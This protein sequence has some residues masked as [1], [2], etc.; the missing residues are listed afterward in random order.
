MLKPDNLRL[1]S[2]IS[3]HD[4]EMPTLTAITAS[5][6]R[7][8]VVQPRPNAADTAKAALFPWLYVLGHDV[9][10]PQ[11]L[12]QVDL[13]ELFGSTKY[14]LCRYNLQHDEQMITIDVWG[15]GEALSR[16]PARDIR[17]KLNEASN[18][19]LRTNGSDWQFSYLASDGLIQR[20]SFNLFDENFQEAL[21]HIFNPETVERE[22]RINNILQAISQ[23]V[24][25]RAMDTLIEQEGKDILRDKE[26]E[27]IRELLQQK[28]VLER[29]IVTLLSNEQ[30]RMMRDYQLSA[31]DMGFV[32]AAQPLSSIS[33]QDIQHHS[34]MVNRLRGNLHATFDDVVIDISSRT[35]FY[36]ILAAIAVQFRRQ[37]AIPVNDLIRPPDS[38]PDSNRVRPLGKPG[39]YLDLTASAEELDKSVSLLLDTLNLR[40]RFKATNRGEPFP[41]DVG[42]LQSQ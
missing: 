25:R 8:L 41:E 2:I 9:W 37:D 26:P 42:M 13:Q 4:E 40:Y 17:P 30:I 29:H 15:V 28:S 34:R 33:L 38:P 5:I 35:G 12:R 1:Q 21:Y 14:N 6:R 11:V 10:H 39:W 22:V 31:T 16:S 20:Y 24:L 19:A 23:G 36:Y 27:E 7:Y 3:Q 32:R 18:W